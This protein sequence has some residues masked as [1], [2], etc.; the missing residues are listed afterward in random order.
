[1]SRRRETPTISNLER[2]LNCCR[3]HRMSG[4]ISQS[5]GSSLAFDLG[6][7]D[8][9]TRNNHGGR[10]GSFI[11]DAVTAF[12]R[13]VSRPRCIV[14]YNVVRNIKTGMCDT[15]PIGYYFCSAWIRR[16]N[17]YQAVRERSVK[18]AIICCGQSQSQ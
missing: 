13:T 2:V 10:Y 12:N 1:M 16:G 8:D 5:E 17:H 18:F 15:P 14:E 4:G 7:S 6:S 9:L 3:C 11:F